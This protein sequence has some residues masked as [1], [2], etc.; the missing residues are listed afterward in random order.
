MIHNSE[1]KIN[2]LKLE[3][4]VNLLKYKNLESL[5]CAVIKSNAYGHGLIK[6]AN[7]LAGAGVNYF[8]VATIDEAIKLR[9]LGKDNI[10]ILLLSF[11]FLPFLDDIYKYNITPVVYSLTCMEA[12]IAK[13][14][15]PVSIHIEIDTGM[16]RTGIQVL[17]FNEMCSLINV[18]NYLT[19][20]GV[21][22]HFSCADSNEHSYTDFQNNL[23]QTLLDNNKL[24]FSTGKFIHSQNSAAFLDV[25]QLKC[26]LTRV[27]IMLYGIF[28]IKG[29]ISLKLKPI[30]SWHTK[31]VQIKSCPIG[32][33]VSYGATWKAKKSSIIATIPVGY[34]DGYPRL[35]SN[36]GFVLINGVK[37]PIVGMIC[38][39]Y[40]M[41]DITEC[42]NVDIDSQ[43][44]LIGKQGTQQITVED[45]ADWAM[46]IPYEVLCN[47]GKRSNFKYIGS[48]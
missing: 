6:I 37:A 34:A 30:L 25:K 21:F 29:R 8:A 7:K 41:V 3:Q 23:F 36:K 28:P 1:V 32:T 22:T 33:C 5:L 48:D 20:D 47:V 17:E 15:K 13:V 18:N 44:I 24:F 46:T 43:V 16:G 35:V 40:M 11:D 38:M 4:N 9:R 10:V 26:N 31:I 45:L 12:L 2:L 39:D 27:G 14:N 19:V 42:N